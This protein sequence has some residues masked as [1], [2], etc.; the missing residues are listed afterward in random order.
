MIL[1]EKPYVSDFLKQTLKD[2]QIPIVKTKAAEN[3]LSSTGYNFISEADAIRIIQSEPETILYT[4]SENALHWVEKNLPGSELSRRIDLFKNKVLLRDLLKDLYPNYFYEK[5]SYNDLIKRNLPELKYPLII[6][7]AIGFFSIGVQQV[8]S[9]EQLNGAIEA[10]KKEVDEF[11]NVYPG[12]V[13]N[14]DT[15]I[16]E[17]Y[18]SGDEFAVDVFYNK[19]GK[20]VILNIMKHLFASDEDVSD[21]VYISSKEIIERYSDH[22]YSFLEETGKRAQVKNFPAHV[23][24][25]INTHGEII[26]VE[27]NPLRFGAW[28]TTADFAG[29]ALN[30]NTYENLWLQKE[31]DW[32]IVFK[33]KEDSIFSMM[34]LENSTGVPAKDIQ[35]F[36]H[37]EC[38]KLLSNILEY[39][40]TDYK[41]YKVFAFLFSETKADNIQEL[42]DM[43]QND[44]SDYITT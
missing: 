36:N 2:L 7:P 35:S 25:R 15:F 38:Q 18:I 29:I 28:C 26:P 17:E 12:E 9:E 41:Q 1:L 11:L 10:I 20:P 33:G 43:L 22:F 39:R 8:N 13:L 40:E 30:T 14:T 6:K 24:I 34:V 16:I 3:I 23:E 32:N 44:L 37:A 42:Y 4:N 5:I 21:R 27:I 31:P 19:T